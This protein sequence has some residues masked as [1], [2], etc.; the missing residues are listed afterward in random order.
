MKVIMNIEFEVDTDD[1]VYASSWAEW[2]V[3]E[4]ES[5]NEISDID[6]SIELWLE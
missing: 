2:L 6:Y 4:L 5:H 3:A 1:S